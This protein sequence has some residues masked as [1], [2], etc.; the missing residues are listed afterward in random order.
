MSSETRVTHFGGCHCGAVRFEVLAPPT[1]KITLCNC[2]VCVKKQLKCFTVKDKYFKIIRGS[3][4]LSLYTFNTRQAKH[5]F[6]EI[7]G[8]Q[9]FYKPRSNP[10][11]IGVVYYCVDP[12]TLQGH[13]QENTFDGQNWEECIKTVDPA[14]FIV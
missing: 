5:Y 3:E 9:S 14:N 4:H 11:G 2:S 13:F 7:C 1:V 6:C 12:G 10:D 8:V